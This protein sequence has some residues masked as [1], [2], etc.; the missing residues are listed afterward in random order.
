MLRS[1]VELEP[2]RCGGGT[3][4]LAN[5]TIRTGAN[6]PGIQSEEEVVDHLPALKKSCESHCPVEKKA[7]EACTGRIAKLGEGDCEGWY[8][9][10]LHCV[11]HCVAPKAFKPLK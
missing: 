8:F 5:K 1:G 3:W 2:V 4:N 7:Y 6:Y 9:D 11:D 10:L